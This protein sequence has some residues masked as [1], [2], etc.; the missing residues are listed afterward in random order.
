MA[1][2]E[3]RPVG[4]WYEMEVDRSR[5]QAIAGIRKILLV[6]ST[7][8]HRSIPRR[9]QTHVSMHVLKRSFFVAV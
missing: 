9:G 1:G 5:D 4:L 3:I 2:T 8:K 6:R 7:G